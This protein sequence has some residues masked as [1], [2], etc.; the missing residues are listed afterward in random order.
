[1][2]AALDADDDFYD[3]GTGCDTLDYSA[4]TQGVTVDLACGTASGVEIGEDTISGFET[5]V[6]GSGDDH[7][8]VSDAPM[9]LAGGGGENIFEFAPAKTTLGSGSIMHEIL[10]FEF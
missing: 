6:G 4:T 9:V 7:F 3:G 2:I 5:V 10:D 1:V 8:V